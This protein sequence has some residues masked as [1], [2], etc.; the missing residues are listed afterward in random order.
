M[1]I[2]LY[3]TSL[4][5]V[6]YSQQLIFRINLFCTSNG[7]KFVIWILLLLKF[8]NES[9]FQGRIQDLSEGGGGQVYFGTK[10]PD[11]GTKRRTEGEIFFTF[12]FAL[13]LLRPS[14]KKAEIV[15]FFVVFS[16][17]MLTVPAY[18]TV[19]ILRCGLYCTY[20]QQEIR[21]KGREMYCIYL[22]YTPS[23]RY[24]LHTLFYYRHTYMMFPPP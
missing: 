18:C 22:Q 6:F 8:Y 23:A 7:W 10:N 4:T 12:L 9:A 17:L 5:T 1:C 15:T 13:G 19:Q 21:I 14:V 2:H 3:M 20:I 16:Y 11:L 24:F